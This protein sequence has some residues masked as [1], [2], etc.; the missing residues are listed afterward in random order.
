MQSS[1]WEKVP[2]T[3]ASEGF[4]W[5]PRS[6]K[7]NHQSF[8]VTGILGGGALQYLISSHDF[9]WFKGY[10]SNSLCDG[11]SPLWKTSIERDEKK[12]VWQWESPMGWWPNLRKK[13]GKNNNPYNLPASKHKFVCLA[14]H[15]DIHPWAIFIKMISGRLIKTPKIAPTIHPMV[16]WC[17]SYVFYVGF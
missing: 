4:A 5:D 17:Y 16:Y 10:H 8:L 1:T 14:N 11:T 13:K 2:V 7:C 12:K 9:L 15:Q 3:V 6:K